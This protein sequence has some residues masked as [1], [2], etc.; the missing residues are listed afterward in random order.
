MSLQ[1]V[2]IQRIFIPGIRVSGKKSRRGFSGYLSRIFPALMNRN[3]PDLCGVRGSF[4]PDNFRRHSLRSGL[5]MRGG[6]I[7]LG[8]TDD[9]ASGRSRDADSLPLCTDQRRSFLRGGAVAAR[10][11]HTQEVAGSSPAPATN[12]ASRCGRPGVGEKCC[13]IYG[14]DAGYFF[15]ENGE[16]CR[17][18]TPRE[19]VLLGCACLI[20]CLALVAIIFL[21]GGIL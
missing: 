21:I 3:L 1:P 9:H 4:S 10:L 15:D 19:C 2:D 16:Q 12:L 7:F 8:H 14:S 6:W 20:G 13:G 18:A 11:V 5:L 17:W